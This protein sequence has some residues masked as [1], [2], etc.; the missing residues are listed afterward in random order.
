MW[1]LFMRMIA[2]SAALGPYAVVQ[3]NHER[4]WEHSGSFYDSGDS[5]GEY[6][7]KQTP[8]NKQTSSTL[9]GYVGSACHTLFFLS[10][11]CIASQSLLKVVLLINLA[12]CTAV[13]LEGGGEVCVC[14]CVW[15]GGGVVR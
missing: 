9:L 3:G 4:D 12:L 7:N 10:L 15:G 8:K 1:A 14:V 6:V 13:R 2:P 5:W 11:C